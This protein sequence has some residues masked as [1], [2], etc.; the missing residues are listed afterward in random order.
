MGQSIS[1][2][3]GAGNVALLQA[4]ISGD[5]EEVKREVGRHI[6]SD[7]C[8]LADFVNKPC[9]ARKDTKRS[10]GLLAKIISPGELRSK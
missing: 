7:K 5:M 2:S 9:L 4:C 6:A 1:R 3:V 10:C 8:S